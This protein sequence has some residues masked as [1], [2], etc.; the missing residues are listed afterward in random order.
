MKRYTE[1]EKNIILSNPDLTAAQLVRLLPG[2]SKNSVYSF[3][4]LFC[5]TRVYIRKKPL[6]KKD[7][8]KDKNRPVI[9][10]VKKVFVRPPAVYSNPDYSKL[11]V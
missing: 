3:R 4:F 1:Q 7:P 2:R 8:I 6:K 5:E 11:Y 9:P 10:D